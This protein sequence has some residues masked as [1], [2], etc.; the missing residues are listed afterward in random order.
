MYILKRRPQGEEKGVAD[1]LVINI[2]IN[3]NDKCGI[4]KHYN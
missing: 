1:A 2:L 4:S 3:L